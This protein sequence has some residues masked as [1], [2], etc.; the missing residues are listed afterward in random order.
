LS[1]FA[2]TPGAAAAPAAAQADRRD[3]KEGECA[4][5][6]DFGG[7]CFGARF[8]DFGFV[9]MDGFG[10]VKSAHDGAVE[11]VA[12]ASAEEVAPARAARAAGERGRV[13]AR[14]HEA[15]AARHAKKSGIR[16]SMKCSTGR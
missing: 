6:R 16:K 5:E 8:F 9:D 3:G 12:V 13:M 4:F 10:G 7:V 1:G 11:N 14:V 15:G 2:G